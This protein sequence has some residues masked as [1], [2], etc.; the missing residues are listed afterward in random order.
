MTHLHPT[1]EG[2]WWKKTFSHWL[3]ICY[4]SIGFSSV[5]WK[6]HTSG[7]ESPVSL[8]RL[9]HSGLL[10]TADG[11]SRSRLG[12]QSG[13]SRRGDDQ[14]VT[15]PLVPLETAPESMP[16]ANIF[17]ITRGN[18]SWRLWTGPRGRRGPS[19]SDLTES[20]EAV[21]QKARCCVS[22]AWCI[23]GGL[24]SSHWGCRKGLCVNLLMTSEAV[25]ST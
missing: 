6:C 18:S 10:G 7:H 11:V 9:R 5:L 14:I 17:I 13:V 12:V 2:G 15:V 19:G 20:A 25:L 16:R 8:L 1:V 4:L 3:F 23:V 22:R 24:C 21:D